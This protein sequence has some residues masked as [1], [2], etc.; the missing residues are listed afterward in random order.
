MYHVGQKID[1]LTVLDG[2][3]T[4]VVGEITQIVGEWMW[5]KGKTMCKNIEVTDKLT[6]H[7]KSISTFG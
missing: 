6:V 4:K 2:S 3:I 7:D 1:W 5:V